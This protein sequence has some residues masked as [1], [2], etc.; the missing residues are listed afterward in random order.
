MMREAARNGLRD[1]YV[2][3]VHG[4]RGL[5]GYLSVGGA[6]VDLSPLQTALLDALAK[7]AFWA[8]LRV[9]QPEI[10]EEMTAPVSVQLTRREMEALGR[11]ADGLTS[12]EIGQALNISSNTVDWYMNG[13]Q[14][15]LGAKNRHHAVAIA[16]RLGLIN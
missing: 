8:V 4:D 5:V 6:P 13:I 15:K 10:A 2:F 14:D 7:R 3:P 1:G 16:F 11:L 12:N 9:C